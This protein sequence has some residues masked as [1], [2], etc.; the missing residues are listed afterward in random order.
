MEL[1]A[2]FCQ[3]FRCHGLEMVEGVK[4]M[5]KHH[6]VAG[7]A[8][9]AGRRFSGRSLKDDA[10]TPTLGVVGIDVS[11]KMCYHRTNVDTQL[12]KFVVILASVARQI[13]QRPLPPFPI[14]EDG[15]RRTGR[16]NSLNPTLLSRFVLRLFSPLQHLKSRVVILRQP[17]GRLARGR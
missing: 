1:Q 17:Q 7:V 16:T 6:E 8:D 14:P 15:F 9:D 10:H 13:H 4:V 3:P 11:H 5:V 12:S 2:D